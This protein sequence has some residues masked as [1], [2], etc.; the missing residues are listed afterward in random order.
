MR[1]TADVRNSDDNLGCPS[2][3]S[4]LFEMRS[5]LWHSVC[6]A[7]WSLS[8]LE[9]SCSPPLPIY[10]RSSG[11]TD[12]C[13]HAQ[14]SMDSRRPNSYRHKCLH[15]LSHSP[16]PTWDPTC[17]LSSVP[18]AEEHGRLRTHMLEMTEPKDGSSLVL[19]NQEC[20]LNLTYTGNFTV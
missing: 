10:C 16:S 5:L 9:F 15:P 6:Q 18:N 1:A 3:C 13:Y 12:M 4:T 14:N 7:S 17:S 19:I 2:L 20:P 8:F 11:V